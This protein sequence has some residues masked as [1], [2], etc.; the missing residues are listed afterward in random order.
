MTTDRIMSFLIPVATVTILLL[1]V[2]NGIS[3]NDFWWHVKVGERIVNDGV[4]PTN[5]IFSWYGVENNIPW[6]AHEW[7]ADVIFYLVYSSMGE[8][9]IFILSVGTGFA[10]VWLMWR[11]TKK[12][13][14]RNWLVTGL[15]FCLLAVTISLFFYGRPHI[16]GFLLIFLEL[17]CL[18][19]FYENRSDKK[20]WLVPV[21]TV[22][23]SNLHGGS[24]N[25]SYILCIVFAVVGSLELKLGKIESHRISNKDILKL[26]VLIVLTICAIF[27][28]PVGVKTFLYPYE[29]FGD[30]LS[31][32]V[33]SEWAPPDAKKIGDLILYFLPI[34]IMSFCLIIYEGKIRAIDAAVMALF[35][36]LFFR[37]IR[38]IML[39]YISA[40][41][42]A[43]RYIYPIKVKSLNSAWEKAICYAVLGIMLTS[44]TISSALI[45]KN[46]DDIISK[47]MSVKEVEIVKNDAPL[48]IFNDYNLGETLIFNN[49]VVFFDAR[50]DLFSRVGVLADGISLMMLNQMNENSE[51]SYVDPDEIIA[52]Y[53]FDAILIMKDRPLYPYLINSPDNYRLIYED[54]A[55]A[56]FRVVERTNE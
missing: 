36:F 21:I 37:S 22:F 34:G 31:L 30:N 25:M 43:F 24:S 13:S 45:L 8:I 5:D 33:I 49:I 28:N 35:V 9:G 46:K 26:S 40:I 55:V 44:I 6:T 29:S 1:C 15:F 41:F 20:I 48:R 32:S 10:L 7:L 42:W 23:W 27:I 3:G 56:Y 2:Q 4:V 16:F 47:Q 52:N 17:K 11:E 18:Y 19:D 50:A 14:S 53:G 51:N 12:Y 39:W 38:F 54:K